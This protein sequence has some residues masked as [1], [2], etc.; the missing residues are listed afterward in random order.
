MVC[1]DIHDMGNHGD[2]PSG[3]GKCILMTTNTIMKTVH[4]TQQ[5]LGYPSTY[6]MRHKTLTALHENKG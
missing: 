2:M 6:R 1:G 3:Q 4:W 5:L